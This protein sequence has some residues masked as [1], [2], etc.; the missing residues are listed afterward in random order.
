MPVRP[1]RGGAAGASQRVS[2]LTGRLSIGRTT[3]YALIGAGAIESVKVD[4]LSRVPADALTGYVATSTSTQPMWLM[5][6][7]IS[8]FPLVIRRRNER[9]Q[10]TLAQW[11][12]RRLPPMP[13]PVRVL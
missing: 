6:V 9:L 7:G 2:G 4:R 5:A 3:M 1:W 11:P 12:V 13:L 10:P 8:V